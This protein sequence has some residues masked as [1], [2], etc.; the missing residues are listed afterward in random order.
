MENP[1]DATQQLPPPPAPPRRLVRRPNQGPLGGVCAGVAE[2]FN[3]D[4]TIV[5]I[6]A[7]VLAFMGP[8]VPGYLIAWAFVPKDDGAS[9]AATV[10][11]GAGQRDRG[12]QILGI[13]LM[14]VAVSILWGD[15]WIPGKGWLVPLGLIGLGAWLLLRD[16]ESA[17]LVPPVPPAPP[18][19][20]V[21]PTPWAGGT[22][23]WATPA[24]PVGGDATTDDDTAIEASS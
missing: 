13:V 10:G 4:P 5:R 19:P 14:V 15:W 18:V 23:P 2:Y 12:T 22:A 24:P 21:P 1:S 11:P 7:V 17:P 3:V 16:D 8:G 20:P 9:I 6:A